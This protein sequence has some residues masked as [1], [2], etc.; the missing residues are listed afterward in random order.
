MDQQRTYDAEGLPCGSGVGRLHGQVCPK[1][2]RRQ[3][4]RGGEPNLP[5]HTPTFATRAGY[6]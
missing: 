3:Q 1:R 4:R 2:Q 6:E 5:Q